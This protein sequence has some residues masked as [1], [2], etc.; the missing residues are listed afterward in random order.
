MNKRN[1][2][3]KASKYIFSDSFLLNVNSAFFDM[4][5]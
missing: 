3:L 4:C 2:F 5:L 1:L